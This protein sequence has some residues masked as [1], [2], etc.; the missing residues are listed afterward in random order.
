[1]ISSPPK[2]NTVK[3]RLRRNPYFLK[4]FTTFLRVIE[5]MNVHY[6]I[7]SLVDGHT[8]KKN[9]IKQRNKVLFIKS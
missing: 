6:H 9:V 1:M 4:S 5:F 2:G 7:W 3:L 8:A